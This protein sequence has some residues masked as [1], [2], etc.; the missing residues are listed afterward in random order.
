MEYCKQRPGPPLEGF[1]ELLWH[2]EGCGQPH[3]KERLLPDGSMELVVNLSQDEVRVY[4][5][6]DHSR[7]ERLSGCVLIGPHSEFFVI[8][9]AARSVMG[10]HFRP[11]GAFPFLPLPAGELHGLHVGL[12]DLWGGAAQELRERLL[13]ANT[14]PARFAL[15]EAALLARLARPLVRHPAVGFALGEFNFALQRRSIAEVTDDTGLSA[16]RF[17]EVFKQQVGLTPKL[18]CRVR[19]F[20]EVIHGVPVGGRVD[21]ADLALRCG[22]FDQAHFIHD[23]R[24]FS[25]ISPSAYAERCTGHLNHVLL[26]T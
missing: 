15:L 22:Y 5:R 24:A 20:Q 23:F 10:V 13:A 3:A 7:Y 25:G 6:R 18:Y 17:I 11:G 14:V 2:Y 26:E 8:D 9:T 12:E 16:R 4:D 1:V 19:R 21:W